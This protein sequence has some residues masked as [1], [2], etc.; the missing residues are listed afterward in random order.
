MSTNILLRRSA[1]AGRIPTTAQLNLGELA[2]NT[3]DGKIYFKKYD[4]VANTES[5]ID[6]SSNLDAAAILAELLTVDGAGTGLDSDLLDGF[7]GT[8]Y[9]DWANFTNT[10]TTVTA[11]T[12]GSASEVPVFTVDADGRLTAANTVSV[13]GVSNTTWDAANTTFTID[14]ADGNSYNTIIVM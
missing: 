13:A 5:I 10:A 11:G 1:V 3:A 14:T 8:Y 12:Y 2:I 9:L 6:I 4:A 7:E